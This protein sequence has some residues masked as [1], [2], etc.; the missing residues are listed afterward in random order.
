MKTR[1]VTHNVTYTPSQRQ[2]EER[3]REME[4]RQRDG[5]DTQRE[6]EIP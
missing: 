6:R 5:E 4:E 3:H 2:M 1:D